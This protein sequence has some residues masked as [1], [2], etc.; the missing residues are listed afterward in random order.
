MNGKSSI[1][2]ENTEQ[3]STI[4]E[5]ETSG[6]PCSAA[7]T[8]DGM[9]LAH[10]EDFTGRNHAAMLSDFVKYCLDTEPSTGLSPMLLP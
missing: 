4:L 9:I 8:S 10:R 5:I 3:M 2:A 6:A 7:L 1:F